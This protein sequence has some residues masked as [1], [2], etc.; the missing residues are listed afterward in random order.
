MDENDRIFSPTGTRRRPSK[1]QFVD[2]YLCL[3]E[4]ASGLPSPY[5]VFRSKRCQGSL[6]E[7]L[8]IAVR[9]AI[10]FAL[11][12]PY[13]FLDLLHHAQQNLVRLGSPLRRPGLGHSLALDT[14]GVDAV[15][16]I[17]PK[18][19]AKPLV[20]LHERLVALVRARQLA[21]RVPYLLP[22]LEPR[23]GTRAR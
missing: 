19:G 23:L 15:S 11:C 1:D 3:T 17:S 7:T 16:H 18:L 10:R 4:T 2:A 12:N 20:R 8:S 22:A 14:I 6:Q 9:T 5:I 21:K 13:T